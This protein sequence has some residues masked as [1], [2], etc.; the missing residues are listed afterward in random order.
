MRNPFKKKRTEISR[1]VKSGKVEF[2]HGNSIKEGVIF[3]SPIYSR[4]LI[5]NSVSYYVRTD[6]GK[7]YKIEENAIEEKR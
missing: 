2:V 5:F 7:V 3:G 6:E 4:D 1:H